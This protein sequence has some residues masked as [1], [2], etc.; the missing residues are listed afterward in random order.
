M[1]MRVSLILAIVLSTLDAFSAKPVLSFKNGTFK[2]IQFTDLHWIK[3]HEYAAYNDSTV[4]L[5]HRLIQEEQP[6]L[7]IITGDVVVSKGAE[8]GWKEV[9]RPMTDLKVP[10]AIVFGNH[11][12]ESDMPKNEVLQLLQKNPYNLSGN[13]DKSLSGEGNCFLEV[14]SVGTRKTEC[15]LYL[16]DSH[17]YSSMP[18]VEG[19]D[20]IKNDQIQWYRRTSKR[21]SSE[22]GKGIPALAFFHIPFPEYELVRNQE[23]VLGNH[24]ETVCSPSLNSGLFASFVEMGDVMG[25]FVGHDHNNDFAGEL[26]GI[27]LAYGRK[28]GYASAYHEILKRGARVIVLHENERAFDSYIRTSGGQEF[29]YSFSS[30]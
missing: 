25:V 2:I 6:D 3:G 18:Q 11:D 23:N 24:S 8:E 20:W 13:S 27:C 21:F 14:K 9:I 12:T 10:F 28:T 26:D 17:A 4:Q 5:M 1:K 22:A 7:V 16:F 29:D 19:Y 15:V 30:K